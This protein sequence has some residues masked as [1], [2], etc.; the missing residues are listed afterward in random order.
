MVH[1][2]GSSTEG[3]EY[4]GI[5]MDFKRFAGFYMIRCARFNIERKGVPLW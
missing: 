4:V 1:N 5:G 2:R 3:N